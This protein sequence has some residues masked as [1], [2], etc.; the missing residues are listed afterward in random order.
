MG[1]SNDD[2]KH[3]LRRFGL[4]ASEAEADYYGKDG[5][6]GA[7]QRMVEAVQHP[8]P[9]DADLA[10]FANDGGLVQVRSVQVRWCTQLLATQRPLIHSLKLFWHDHFATSAMKVDK[11]LMM[12]Q[13]LETLEQHA[14]GPFPQLLVAVSKDPAMLYWLDNHE[15]VRGKPNE[16][17]A[18]EVMELFTLGIGHYSEQDVM[19]AARAFTGW[20]FVAPGRGRSLRA[21]GQIR[22]VESKQTHDDGT[23]TILGKSADYDGDQVLAMLCA[24][25]QTSLHLMHKAWEWFA[26]PGPD[27]KLV[28]RLATVWRKEG[29]TGEGLFRTIATAPEFR[30]ERA[31]R[32]V[33]K[34]PV[35]FCTATMRQV[36]AGQAAVQQLNAE[37]KRPGVAGALMNAAT[38][39]MGMELLYPPD[40]AGWETGESWISSA[41][42]VERIKWADQ[43]FPRASQGLAYQLLATDPTPEGVARRIASVFDADLPAN[44]MDSLR[45]AA[46][47][48][49][50]PR[51]TLQNA[52]DVAVAVT[53]LV[54]GSPEFQ[55]A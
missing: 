44:K 10:K 13:H 52:R 40:V 45:E 30:S 39:A 51:L 50:G 18:R 48:A 22:F 47:S 3:L 8:E 28:E 33:V 20:T 26:Y 43:V 6:S 1:K 29:M 14:L 7:V 38:K 24:H 35:H 4:G 34:N 16:N 54:F 15:N 25:P 31:K 41:T 42:M 32:A 53:R 27:A 46:R 2:V 11:P 19:E 36:G 9:F 5:Y 12:H 17:F 23:K 49:M 55:F 37:G 21:K